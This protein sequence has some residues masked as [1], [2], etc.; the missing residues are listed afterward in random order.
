MIPERHIK[1]SVLSL[2]ITQH[3]GY[4]CR[5]T[6]SSGSCEFKEGLGYINP[7]L[8][9]KPIKSPPPPPHMHTFIH[10]A[11]SSEEE[12]EREHAM[13]LDLYF[14]PLTKSNLKWIKALMQGEELSKC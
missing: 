8:K 12:K 4:G 5:R 6:R 10:V 11:G 14:S 1:P 3:S 9:T 2:P 7:Y 13:K